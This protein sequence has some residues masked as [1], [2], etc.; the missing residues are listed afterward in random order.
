MIVMKLKQKSI[1]A[2]Y[3][4]NYCLIRTTFFEHEHLHPQRVY[5]NFNEWVLLTC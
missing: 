2:E 4:F 1:Y 3:F 5:K